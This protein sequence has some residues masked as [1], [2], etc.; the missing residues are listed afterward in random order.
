MLSLRACVA[1]KE[2]F[3]SDGPDGPLLTHQY[4]DDQVRPRQGFYDSLD[5][6][7]DYGD[8][9]ILMTG[10]WWVVWYVNCQE[11]GL[12]WIVIIVVVLVLVFTYVRYLKKF[13]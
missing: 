2:P 11:V 8:E 10:N 13:N 1:P 9:G 6:Y 7:E 3:Y 12:F 4:Y 5:A